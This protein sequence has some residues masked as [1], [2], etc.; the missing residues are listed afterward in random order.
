MRS[1]DAH[2]RR[3]PADL[4]VVLNDL[5]LP[6]SLRRLLSSVGAIRLGRPAGWRITQRASPRVR[7]LRFAIPRVFDLRPPTGTAQA[8]SQQRHQ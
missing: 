8:T 3:V 5:M 4:C 6:A 2:G 1:F 7:L